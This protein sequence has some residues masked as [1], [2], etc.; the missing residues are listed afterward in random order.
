MPALIARV[1]NLVRAIL[2]PS[3]GLQVI[4]VATLMALLG[5]GV[6]GLVVIDR[7]RSALRD[8][9]LRDSLTTADLAIALSAGYMGA[10][11]AA[12]RELASRPMLRAAAGN[13]DFSSL[14][15]DLDRWSVEHPNVTVAIND[16]DGRIRAAGGSGDKSTLG[17]SPR[18]SQDWLQAVSTGQPYLGAPGVSSVSKT[19]RI[20]YAVPLRDEAGDIRGVLTTSIQ[21]EALSD[22]ITSIH[23][24]PN[25]HAS[26]TDRER[27]IILAHPDAT[28]IL[29]PSSTGKNRAADRMLAGERGVLEAT[30]SSGEHILAAFGPVPGLPWAI[31]IQQPSA[32]A[33]APLD[34][35]ARDAMR[36]VGATMVL[37]IAL[38]AVLAVRIG[39]PLR[40][41]RATAEAMAG[42]D[43]NRR[44]ALDRQDEAGEL[45]RAFDHMADRLQ[46]SIG[47]A[48]E[49]EAG[50][51]AVMD[52][53]AD[54]IVTFDEGGSI[55]SCNLAAERL[56]GYTAAELVGQSIGQLVP[57]AALHETDTTWFASVLSGE[58]AVSAGHE[59]E[60]RRQDGAR[61]PL[62]LAT[63]ETWLD[64]RRRLIVVARDISQRKHAEQQ[65]QALAQSEKLRALGQMASGIAHDLNQS[66]MLVASYS[67]LAR[68]ALEHD[69]PKLDELHDLFA[70][71][72]QAALD[73]GE[74]VKRLLLFTRAPVAQDRQIVDLSAV[75]R[76]VAQL[77]APRWRDAAQA[78]GRPISLHIETA[79][80]P[81][82]QGSPAR[83][84]EAMTNL[85]F[86]AVD[87]LPTGGTIRLRVVA[88]GEHAVI[89]VTDS[90][91][92]MSAEVQ[93]R[94]F[95]P[96]FT[97][98]G[99][100]G[101][102][103]GLPMVFG[104]VEQHGGQIDVRSSPG[105]GTTFRISF[106]LI[107]ASAA[108]KPPATPPVAFGPLRPLRVLAVDD[109]PAM[110][111]A[112][113][114][115][116]RPGGHTVSVAESAEEALHQLAVKTFDVVVSD[117]GMG[118]G[119]N[120]W[121]L[122]AEVQRRW[123]EVR[124]V[125]ATGWGAAID[126]GD[127]RS[128]GVQAVLAKP[129]LPVELTAALAESN[130]AT[131]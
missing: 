31:L 114:R 49:S 58:S 55:D 9:I 19:P 113:V 92:G 34:D 40:R 29:T 125:L 83:L 110:T 112:V 5:G 43:L 86:N 129:Y 130:L 11:Q 82:T 37:A 106:P 121:E 119:M 17:Q 97:T 100:A 3:L 35:M 36:L 124:F 81:I 4:G 32:D 95:E 54:A 128:K 24:G 46:A 42:G 52:S 101:T 88:E 77:T 25:A 10:A 14:N 87:A 16:L 69:P 6:V 90:G 118:A 39:R 2:Q 63:S 74:T 53:V 89:E 71:A 98:K 56:F 26:L 73:G 50:I 27:R 67:D 122:A 41:L 85:I 13:G 51:R 48:N 99:N 57:E 30:S 78:E 68:Q 66:L 70:T 59:C 102:G 20:V 15:L 107:E 91:L 28:R 104:I 96:F 84:R 33:F 61:L 131:A 45:G 117:M 62:E 64:G 60:G 7:A 47:R 65:R 120:G 79:G 72:T 18:V 109:E 115:M 8:N 93:A 22:A 80:H 111:R 44:A 126:P 103:L 1:K 123:P 108:P 116:L 38:G 94:V 21:L 12:A 23:A 127:A 75:V 105:D 76:D